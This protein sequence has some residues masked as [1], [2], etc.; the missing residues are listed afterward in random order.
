MSY[1]ARLKNLRSAEPLTDKADK[2]PSVSFVSASRAHIENFSAPELPDDAPHCAA[3]NWSRL[4]W[5][6]DHEERLGIA[7]DHDGFVPEEAEQTAR[8]HSLRRFMQAHMPEPAGD[9][10]LFCGETGG[11]LHP[12]I[13]QGHATYAHDACWTGHRKEA[14]A[15]LIHMGVLP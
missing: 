9:G 8:I 13:R 1:L 5:W 7:S 11:K 3:C 2:S 12:F 14:E 6:H 10:C 15:A 4:D